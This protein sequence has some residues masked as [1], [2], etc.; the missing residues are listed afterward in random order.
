M[1]D[2]LGQY[3]F[4]P[5]V[6]AIAG[7]QENSACKRDLLEHIRA[8]ERA[9]DVG[10]QEQFV[11]YIRWTAVVLEG[12]GLGTDRLSASL[13]SL[14]E[15][16]QAELEGALGV[17]V[18][19]FL[20]AG[21]TRLSTRPLVEVELGTA[22]FDASV[23]DGRAFEGAGAALRALR[24]PLARAAMARHFMRR[25][26]DALK[27]N[28][29]PESRAK[30]LRDMGYHLSFLEEALNSG[31]SS[32][33][34]DYVQ[35]VD[36]VLQKAGVPREALTQNLLSIEDVLH[37]NLSPPVAAV[38]SDFLQ[39]ALSTLTNELPIAPS[40]LDPNSPL[41]DL[42]SNYFEA[43][44]VGDRRKASRILLDA[45]SRGV[46]VS[47]IYLEVL[48]PTQYEIGR[49]WQKGEMSVA[50][51][52]F[53]SA[54]TRTVMSQLFPYLESPQV[55]RS[56]IVATAIGDH[57]IGLRMLCDLLEEDGWTTYYLG[58]NMPTESVLKALADREAKLLAISVTMT[59]DLNELSELIQQ[60]RAC[61]PDVEIVVGGYPFKVDENLWRSV[62][63]DG[64]ASDAR[65]AVT[66]VRT[67][68]S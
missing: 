4:G 20:Q 8:L 39:A 61:H 7:E 58:G 51:E 9:L 56:V 27:F 63:A 54:V 38:A 12:L 64:S 50:E 15:V 22:T 59:F 57:D 2:T 10:R 29:D 17:E 18:A 48:Q 45:A 68:G 26:E 47:D 16:L 55:S 30:T 53:C 14:A 11:E 1:K 65:L 43:L 49:L 25:P 60:V 19:S 37:S 40:F 13:A 28:G 23:P 42:A 66:A 46:A 52:H 32:L 3:D 24:E 36:G 44:Q 41:A 34:L 33:F 6:E 62:G 5:W 67:L 31:N 21:Q 35:W